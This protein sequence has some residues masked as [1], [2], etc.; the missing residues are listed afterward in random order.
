MRRG[1]RGDW[2]RS[3]LV[4]LATVAAVAG[5]WMVRAGPGT[6]FTGTITVGS[7]PLSMVI[8]ARSGHTFVANTRSDSVS[9][10][11]TARGTVVRTVAVDGEPGALAVDGRDGRVFVV[12]TS[13][14]GPESVS[15]LDSETGQLLRTTPVGQAAGYGTGAIAVDERRGRVVVTDDYESRVSVLDARRGTVQRTFS[16]GLDPTEVTVDARTG[17]A[18]VADT[19]EDKVLVL[20]VARGRVLRTFSV[21]GSPIAVGV[22]PATGLLSVTGYDEAT[23]TGS[24]TWLDSHS[25]RVVLATAKVSSVVVAD[26]HVAALYTVDAATDSVFVTTRRSSTARKIVSWGAGD[27]LMMTSVT[28]DPRTGRLFILMDTCGQRLTPTVTGC[29]RVIDPRAG[30]LVATILVGGGPRALAID[31]ATGRIFVTNSRGEPSTGARADWIPPWLRDHLSWLPMLG[32][33]ATGTTAG[34]VSVFNVP[35]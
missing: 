8:D 11:D 5:V 29:V 19:S 32:A 27:A 18:Y 13:R 7:A 6:P 2:R 24:V 35:R 14:T 33:P 9:M 22:D 3:T 21:A 28:V 12:T 20:D 15:T 34:T 1:I 16:A 23:S 10:M 30:R 4:G 25:G 26:P 31:G 17:L